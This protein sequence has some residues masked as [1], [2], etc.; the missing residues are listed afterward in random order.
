MEARCTIN[1]IVNSL[2]NNSNMPLIYVYTVSNIRNKLIKCILWVTPV[3]ALI[4]VQGLGAN[5]K[6]TQIAIFSFA[7]FY[8]QYDTISHR[9]SK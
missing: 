2:N 6:V 7:R 8:K 4:V 3:V 9:Q 1:W 5:M